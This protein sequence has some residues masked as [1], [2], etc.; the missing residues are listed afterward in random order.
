MSISIIPRNTVLLLL[1]K[2][3]TVDYVPQFA[4]NYVRF[5]VTVNKSCEEIYK[6]IINVIRSHN[7]QRF[8]VGI[9]SNVTNNKF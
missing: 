8:E 1:K 7:L 5:W 9:D 2:N 4:R 3:E 6:A